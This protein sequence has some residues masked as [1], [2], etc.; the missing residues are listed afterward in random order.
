MREADK[1]MLADHYLDLYRMAFAILQN[2]TDSEDAVQEAL[3]VTM[4]RQLWGDPY[5]Y[6]VAVLRNICLKMKVKNREVLLDNML[7]IPAPEADVNNKRLQRLGELMDLLPKRI[8]EILYLYYEQGYTKAEIARK[9]GL[10]ETM[11]KKLF[12]RGQNKLREQLI[13]MEINDKDIFK[14]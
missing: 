8:K 11:V 2:E 14:P 4:T 3:V 10:S 1:Q 6:C 12:D 5:K 9:K 7:D 13:E